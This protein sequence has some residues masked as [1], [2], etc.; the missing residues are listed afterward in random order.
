LI[1]TGLEYPGVIAPDNPWGKG[2]GISNF[3]Q[4]KSSI[5]QNIIPGVLYLFSAIFPL[6]NFEYM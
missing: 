4:T 5:G 3:H 1:A 6:Y 2:T